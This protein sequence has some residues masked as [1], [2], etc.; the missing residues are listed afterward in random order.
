MSRTRVVACALETR[1]AQAGACAARDRQLDGRDGVAEPR[2]RLVV[3]RPGR[4]SSSSSLSQLGQAR[5]RPTGTQAADVA[6]AQEGPP[7]LS[8]KLRFIVARECNSS[9]HSKWWCRQNTQT[10]R[11]VSRV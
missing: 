10:A 2:A 5:G 6:A 8:I 9:W 1:A 4:A 11:L 3:S 7:W